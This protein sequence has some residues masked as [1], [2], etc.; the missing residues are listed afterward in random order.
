MKPQP[1]AYSG[2]VNRNQSEQD[3]EDLLSGRLD[4]PSS[5]PHSAPATKAPS[6]ESFSNDKEFEEAT[7][8]WQSTHGQNKAIAERALLD[9][10]AKSKS[11]AR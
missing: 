9:F 7:S 8:R 6:R 5:K 4:E 11:T 1:D 3:A 2:L 10:R